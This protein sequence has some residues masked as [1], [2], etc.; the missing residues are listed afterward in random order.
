MPDG[1][2]LD[3]FFERVVYD[4]FEER[5]EELRSEVP[6]FDEFDVGAISDADATPEILAEDAVVGSLVVVI[7]SS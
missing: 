4:G 6:D 5:L 2:D 7:G 3:S 1:Y